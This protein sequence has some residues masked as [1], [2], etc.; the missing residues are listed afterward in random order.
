MAVVIFATLIVSLG[1]TLE[2]RKKRKGRNE[3]NSVSLILENNQKSDGGKPRNADSE[4]SQVNGTVFY[5]TVPAQLSDSMQTLSDQS[6]A[7]PTATESNDHDHAS[8]VER[9]DSSSFLPSSDYSAS[10]ESVASYDSGSS[11]SD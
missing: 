11:S 7:V 8:P 3:S 9:C 4:L 5:K 2:S 10:C 1:T 6:V